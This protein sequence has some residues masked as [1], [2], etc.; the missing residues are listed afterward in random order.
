MEIRNH[1]QRC[2]TCCKKGGPVLHGDDL[3]L[4][5]KGILQLDNLIT[6]R[7]GE[8]VYNP[9]S[10]RVEEATDE[11]VKIAGKG[12]GWECLFYQ[13]EPSTCLIHDDL[14]IECRMLECWNTAKIEETSRTEP[15]GRLEI[16]AEDDT[17]RELII[18]HER[19]CSAE[20][21][22]ALVR[23]LSREGDEKSRLRLEGILGQ[24]LAI[25]EKAVASFGMSLSLELFIFGRPLF[26]T[27][28]HPR[29]G[30]HIVGG[31]VRVRVK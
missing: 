12:P 29:L 8:T 4:L 1:C 27:I 23:R 9:F 24:D 26:K 20:E 31:L 7:K 30:V 13:A 10:E 17:R 18:E 5:T 19:R 15:L 14:P 21:L 22:S 28:N 2:G 25:R 11:L 3:H 6:I 16:L